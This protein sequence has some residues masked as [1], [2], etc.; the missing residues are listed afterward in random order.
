MGP[1]KGTQTPKSCYLF[2]FWGPRRRFFLIKNRMIC[3][4]FVLSPLNAQPW[5]GGLGDLEGFFMD[6]SGS[7][8]VYL[9]VY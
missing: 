2:F 9:G 8:R 4:L 3:D 1:D 7:L 5:A 6:P